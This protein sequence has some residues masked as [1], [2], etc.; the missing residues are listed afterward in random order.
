MWRIVI[1]SCMALVEGINIKGKKKKI[2]QKITTLLF[3]V[4]L[5]AVILTGGISVWSLIHMKNLS[6]E[7]SG[8]LGKK[9]AEDAEM[10]LEQ[11]ASKHLKKLT[12]EKAAFINEKFQTVEAYV[13]GIASLTKQ[14]YENPK[15]YPDRT[16]A[17]PKKE[18]I[19]LAAQLLRSKRLREPSKGQLEELEKLG[20]IQELLVQYNAHND[21]VS[22][23]YLA[24]QSGWMIQA[25]YIAFSK[26]EK[27]EEM[28]DYYEASKRQWYR[29]ALQ[30]KEG[31]TV[32]SDV[33]RDVHGGG[34]CIV[35][36]QPVY[37]NGKIVAVAGVGSY[38]KTVNETVLNTTIGE[39]GYAVLIN[40]NGQIVVSPKISGETAVHAEKIL[41]LRKSSHVDLRKAAEDMT[42]GNTGLTR[43]ILDNQEVYLAYA[44]LKRLGWSFGTIMPVEEVIAPA[45]ESQEVILAL[46]DETEEKQKMAIQ[47]MYLLLISIV[48]AAFFTVS[49]LG[50]IFSQRI[51]NPL[52]TLTADVKQI[53]GG[54]LD[55]QVEVS[56]GD[57]VEELGNAFNQMTAQLKEYIQN[58]ASVTAEK[59]RIRTELQVASKLQA[60]MLPDPSNLLTEGQAFTLHAFMVP[61]KEVGGDFYDFFMLDKN[62][63]A[64]VAADVSGKGVPAALFM[65][66]SRTL[67]RISLSKKKSLAKMAQE[68]NNILCRD[69]KDGMFVT[70]WM[71]ILTL[72]TG[73]LVYVNA[74][75]CHPLLLQNGKYHYLTELGG[76]MLAGLEDSDYQETKIILCPGDM[77]F[78]YS[79]GV[80]EAHNE[81]QELFGEDRLLELLNQHKD[82]EPKSLILKVWQEL[83]QFRGKSEQ[84]D[85]ITML[86][87]R[88]EGSTLMTEEDNN[89]SSDT[90]EEGDRITMVCSPKLE[91][92]QD[93]TDHI[94]L[95]LQ[96]QFP[97]E[98]LSCV[99]IAADEIYSNI[100]RY[101]K[102]EKMECTCTVKQG[103]VMLQFED[104]GV[105]YNPLE[106]ADPNVQTDLE[107]RE[108]GGLGI[109]LV[110]KQMN[111]V[112]YEYKNGKNCLTLVK[113]AN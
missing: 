109:Y 10:A 48:P 14:I 81:E 47:R 105:A 4:V 19:E 12:L 8:E 73:E 65:V 94:K 78:Q 75:H 104:N 111:Q 21:M 67:L 37:Y 76:M 46:T 91:K 103:T 60:D 42:A 68:V 26:Y 74:G 1:E 6:S 38:L 5:S 52:R 18:S 15:G 92:L 45:K 28:P 3:I 66:V 16:V 61:A 113:K 55:F 24:T 44:P 71:G 69:N 43:L 84:F 29:K 95:C 64:I 86:A 36:S 101:S 49:L 85:D 2:G 63:L 72:S 9:A 53:S 96:G 89:T 51:T 58:L 25:D 20:N 13:H 77:L 93:I 70:A 56:T 97:K 57:E 98:I 59:E 33:I 7:T 62:H 88:Y 50:T 80:T 110:K 99:F 41:D 23:T 30:L 32:Y 90:L 112:E 82:T 17:K 40:Q 27:G 102:A 35:C 87:I 39:S 31:E 100:C 107:D 108:L 106:K 83:E 54:N 79:D 11:Q 22:S 34:D